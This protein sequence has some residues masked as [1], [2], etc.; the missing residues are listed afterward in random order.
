LYAFLVA[1]VYSKSRDMT[2]AQKK[3]YQINN[4]A[5]LIITIGFFVFLCYLMILFW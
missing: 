3:A 5:F 4:I 1:I 2:L